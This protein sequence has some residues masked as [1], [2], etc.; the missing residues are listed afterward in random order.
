MRD[1]AGGTL[2]FWSKF[3]A[4]LGPTVAVSIIERIVVGHSLERGKL[5]QLKLIPGIGYTFIVATSTL[6]DEQPANQK[7]TK[8]ARVIH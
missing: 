4:S 3:V 6:F 8:A 1:R 5:C 7:M 2:R